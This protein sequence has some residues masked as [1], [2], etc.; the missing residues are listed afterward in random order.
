M[1]S[2]GQ[3]AHGKENLS[4]PDPCPQPSS[5][6]P[7]SL[8]ATSSFSPPSDCFATVPGTWSLTA[9]DIAI[10]GE[11][12]RLRILGWVPTLGQSLWSHGCA[13]KILAV[14]IQTTWLEWRKRL[15]SKEG[16]GHCSIKAYSRGS[17]TIICVVHIGSLVLD[18]FLERK[19][20]SSCPGNPAG[21]EPH[22]TKSTN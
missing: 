21:L 5:L 8:C 15:F 2:Q 18:H 12:L 9:L 14:T 22:T 16:R 20:F 10:V 6:M 4:S 3:M 13:T 1:R 17:L 11:D 7:S 19:S